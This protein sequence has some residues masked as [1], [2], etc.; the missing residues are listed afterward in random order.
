MTP[1][2]KRFRTVL[3]LGSF[4]F[5]GAGFNPPARGILFRESLTLPPQE[6]AV[7]STITFE[8]GSIF[9]GNL[10]L[11]GSTLEASGSITGD[12]ASLD[13]QVHLEETAVLF[14]NFVNLG[15]E[16]ALESGARIT[17]TR[18]T[19]EGFSWMP[20]QAAGEAPQPDGG[21][22]NPWYELSVILF[23][24][25][26]FSAVAIL[27]VLLLP[28][29]V[30][31]VARTIIVKP[32]VS[33][34]IGLLTMMAAAALFLLL[35]LTICLSPISVLG[36][37]I[38]LVAVLLGWVAM[39]K[40][41]GMRVCGALGLKA[42]PAV[43]AGVGTAILTLVASSLGYIPLAGGILLLLVMSF[44]LGAVVLTRFGGKNYLI[45]AE[46]AL[47]DRP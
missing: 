43:M 13:S 14:G 38:L 12:V 44:G 15:S 10:I 28:G 42:H 3:V 35:A 39:G 4:L 7:E 2:Q 19:I 21:G 1:L 6:T 37:I 29:P 22:V 16:P 18:Q 33:F 31:Q 47:Q 40:E 26:L 36:S 32:A 30:E 17:G 5:M 23:R 8:K 41:I 45:L 9:N 24:I 11:I 27:I 46:T 34:L 20:S 25:F